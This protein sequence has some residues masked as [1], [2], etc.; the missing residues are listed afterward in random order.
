ML[1]SKIFSLFR[2]NSRKSCFCMFLFI[3]FI[4]LNSILFFFAFGFCLFLF[5][6]VGVF[7]YSQT[8]PFMLSFHLRFLTVEKDGKT[9]KMLSYLSKIVDYG[10][11][12]GFFVEFFFL[13][14]ES[15][16]LMGC[17][18]LFEHNFYLFFQYHKRIFDVWQQTDTMVAKAFGQSQTPRNTQWFFTQWKIEKFLEGI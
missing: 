17:K 12:G 2:C 1:Y 13:L 9:N 8:D 4:I 6:V 7:F 5:V 3:F 11:C 10:N 14:V 18:F 15:V 16:N